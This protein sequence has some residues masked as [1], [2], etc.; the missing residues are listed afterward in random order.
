MKVALAQIN[1]TVGDLTGNVARCVAAVEAAGHA[2]ADL[3]VLPELAV[4]GY[5]PRD[6][7]LD[8]SFIEAT[9]HATADL[10]N[11]TRSGPPVVVGTVM[12]SGEKTPEH[13]GLFNA[14]VLLR[15]GEAHMV[16]AKRLLPVYDV[17]F[18]PRWFV[19]GLPSSPVDVGGL[20]VGF[21][22]CE[23]LWDEGYPVHPGA[24]LIT[25]GAQVLVCLSA[26][27]YRQA[28]M[29]RRVYH[30][31]RQAAPVVYVN[32]VG[33]NDELVFDGRSFALDS[34]GGLAVQL[35]AY[36]EKIAIVDLDTL[37]ST[38]VAEMSIEEELFGALVL[39][40]RD[41]A[42][43]N[44]LSQAYV[45]LSGGIDSAL[46]AVI[47]S[48]AL[49]PER[50]T[51]LTIPSR[52]SDPRSAQCALELANTL[53]VNFVEVPLEPLHAAAEATLGEV[54]DAEGTAA[55]NVQAR[56]R[57]MI[58][59]SYVNHGGGLLL[60]TSNKTELALGYGTLY[61]DLVG[62]L[63]PIGDLTKTQ[64][65]TLVAWLN[66]HRVK[67]PRFILERPPSAELRPNQVDPFDY[68][69]VAPALELLVQDNRSNP[70]M[71]QSEHKRWQAGVI[72][73]VS[74]KAFGRGR[75]VPVTRR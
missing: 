68:D 20:L 33:A 29:A 64:V 53:G 46:V 14:A 62:A 54:L 57:A 66:E 3:V 65:V 19:P 12:P 74:E 42:D 15:G 28:V 48:A 35:P 34:D 49:G 30:A 52:Y 72:L 39:G 31:R 36:Q 11:R 73:K 41:F 51:A 16:A 55:E 63:W 22:I 40:V 56:L 8:S 23:D 13:P 18:E 4:T 10:A 26:S 37:S 24:D 27:P 45:G 71:R 43:K 32:A 70:A 58:L 2:G 17:F 21:L 6:I 25:I 44:K 38:S 67:F 61:G 50:V 75:L 5:P 69:E 9:D 47:A 59:M 7:L 1:T 60:N